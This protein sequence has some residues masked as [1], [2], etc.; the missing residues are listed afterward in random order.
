MQ[1]RALKGFWEKLKTDKATGPDK[2]PTK[3]LQECSV[4]LVW[5]LSCLFELCFA[6]GLFPS[7]WKGATVISRTQDGYAG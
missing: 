1:P 6:H 3:D 5:L 4:E 7:Q 2:N